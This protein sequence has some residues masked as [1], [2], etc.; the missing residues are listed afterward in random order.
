VLLLL[1]VSALVFLSGRFWVFYGKE[2]H[3]R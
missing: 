1:V 3:G 2:Q